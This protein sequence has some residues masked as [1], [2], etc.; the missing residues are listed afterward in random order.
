[1]TQMGI[2]RWPKTTPTTTTCDGSTTTTTTTTT[3]NHGSSPPSPPHCC[4]LSKLVKKLKK[5]SRLMLRTPPSRQS[6]FQCRYDPL[7]YSLNFDTTGCG[8]SSDDHDQ[9]YYQFYAFSSR[10]VA[11]PKT[12]LDTKYTDVTQNVRIPSH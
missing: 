7:S 5:H 2:L 3:I 6:S 8:A 4:S 10:F 9:D 12:V 1:M 11:T